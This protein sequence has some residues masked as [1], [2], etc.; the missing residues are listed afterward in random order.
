MKNLNMA[1]AGKIGSLWGSY[2]VI[3]YGPQYGLERSS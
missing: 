2:G 3:W 1:W